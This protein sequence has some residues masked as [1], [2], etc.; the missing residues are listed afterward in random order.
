MKPIRIAVLVSGQGR[1]TN[2]QA[3]I[4]ACGDGRIDAEVA[5]V[6][7]VKPDAPAMERAAR[8]GIET[9]VVNPRLYA[10]P[11][12]YDR[13]LVGLLQSC[14]VDLVCLAGYMRKLGQPVIDAYRNKIMNIH[15]ALIP[16]FFGQGMY[17]HHVHEAAIERGIRVSGCTVH[18]VDEDYDTGPIV[19]Q[20]VVPVLDEDTPETLAAR[21]L[22]EEHN[23]YAR[24]IQLFAEGRLEISG[25]RVIIR[26]ELGLRDD[27]D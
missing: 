5:V 7:G 26:P 8:A 11:D 20:A 19:L 10:T 21:V 1:G 14:N 13:A 15:P 27:R 22:T 12:D 9:A 24:A 23:T 2:M 4:D 17:G 6:V 25:R 18:F 16:M 3:I